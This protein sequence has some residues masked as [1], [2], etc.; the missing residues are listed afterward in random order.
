LDN[1]SFGTLEP[2]SEEAKTFY[3]ALGFDSSPREP[4]L[5]IA[6]LAGIRAVLL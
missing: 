6:P 1:P 3:L 2:V 5:L 4:M